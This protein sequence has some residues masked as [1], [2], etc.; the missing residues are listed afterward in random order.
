MEKYVTNIKDLVVQTLE[1]DSQIKYKANVGDPMGCFQMGMIHLLGIETPIDFKKAGQYFGNQSLS[2]NSTA[3]QLLGFIAECDGDFSSAFLS[4]AKTESSEKDTYLDKV[5][6][7]RNQVKDYLKMLNLPQTFNEE[8]SSILNDYSKGKDS[9]IGASI[10]IAAICEDEQT[11][12]EAAQLLS[13]SEEYILAI[14]WL[15]QDD[16]KSDHALY[17][18]INENFGKSKDIILNAPKMQV[19]ELDS[20]SILSEQDYALLENKTKNV[21][22]E[23]S[24]LFKK[25]WIQSNEKLIDGVIKKHKDQIHKQTLKE[26]RHEEKI[27]EESIEKSAR[28]I[29]FAIAMVLA[30]IIIINIG[31][32]SAR[33]A[34]VW[35]LLTLLI[36]AILYIPVKFVVSLFK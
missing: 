13:D 6:K 33:T 36:M 23:E 11:R 32:R 2:E 19:I 7:G 8:I 18:K 35:A 5:I 17:E 31:S 22:V 25:E 34:F 4:Y 15:K 10:K 14:S 24:S 16:I 1:N 29:S 20:S 26:K 28:L 30:F 9:K 12:L 27:R 3:N 21:C